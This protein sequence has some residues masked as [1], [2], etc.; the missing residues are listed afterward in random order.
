MTAAPPRGLSPRT[1]SCP[2]GLSSA[3]DA[4]LGAQAAEEVVQLTSEQRHAD[5]DHQRDERD[6]QCVLGRSGTA[7]LGLVTQD[8]A[9]QQSYESVEV[10]SHAFVPSW[11][12][13]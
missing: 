12:V 6:Q 11:I 3:D 5:N 1:A 7:I 8:D 10:V 13:S 2:P 4:D 9:P